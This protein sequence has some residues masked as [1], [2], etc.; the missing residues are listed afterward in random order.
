MMEHLDNVQ[1]AH[2]NELTQ[3]IQQPQFS[4]GG[5]SSTINNNTTQ[6]KNKNSKLAASSATDPDKEQITNIVES[7]QDKLKVRQI[8]FPYIYV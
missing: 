1:R 3:K 2:V 5:G 4:G 6:K 7:K 8:L